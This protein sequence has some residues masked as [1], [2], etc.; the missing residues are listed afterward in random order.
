MDIFEK[1]REI[2]SKTQKPIIFEFGMCDGYHSNLMLQLLNQTG[3]P[4][5]YNGCEPVKKLFSNIRLA[6]SSIGEA[7]AHNVAISSE[8]GQS[9]FY[10]SGGFKKVNGMIVDHYYGSSSIRKPKLT[11]TAWPDMTFDMDQVETITFDSLVE[12]CKLTDQIIDFVWA[13][14]QGAEIDLI[15]GGTKAFNKT[16]YFYTEYNGSE[17]YE[18]CSTSL[19]QITNLLPDFE[20][21]YDF[22]GDVLLKNINL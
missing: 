12:K 2:I 1:L 18:G 14:I 10:V 9:D 11:L 3:K 5:V 4:Y 17:L 19:S 22:G 21:I 16:R 13:D 8:N 6:S 15:N 7:T 20:I